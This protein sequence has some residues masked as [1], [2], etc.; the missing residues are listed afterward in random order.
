MQHKLSANE[1]IPGGK[2]YEHFLPEISEQ[3]HICAEIYFFVLKN[4]LQAKNIFS[5]KTD[6]E[7]PLSALNQLLKKERL[8]E[9]DKFPEV[10]FLQNRKNCFWIRIQT[11]ILFINGSTQE[12]VHRLHIPKESKKLDFNEKS[13]AFAYTL[14]NGLYLLLA[15]GT[16]IPVSTNRNRAITAGQAASRNEFG[17]TKGTFWSPQGSMLAFYQI[18]ERE[19]ADYPLVSIKEPI[20][21]LEKIKYPMAGK[22]SQQVK[23]GLYSVSQNKTIFLQAPDEKEAYLTCL[24]WSPDEKQIYLAELKRSQKV[25]QLKRFSA[26]DGLLEKVLFSESDEKY[27]EPQYPLLFLDEN[28]KRFLWQS[29]RDGFNHLY[30]YDEKGNLQQQLTH[31]DWEVCELSGYEKATQRIIFSSTAQSPLNRNFYAIH[32]DSGNM[33]LLTPEEGVHQIVISEE[34]GLFID[35]F[36]SVQTPGELFL[37]SLSDGK[38]LRTLHHAPNPYAG[39]LMPKTEIGVFRQKETLPEIYYRITYPP[40][41]KPGRKYP[42]LFYVY[43]GPH[44]Q[45]VRNEWNGG[46]KGFERFMANEGYVVFYMD[47]RGSAFRGKA[48]EEAIWLNIGK[49]QLDDYRFALH[50]LLST[51][52]CVDE[53]KVGV[54]GW[55]FGGFMAASLMLKAPDLFQAG[56]AGGAVID[57]AFY[58]TMYTERYMKTPVE[59]PN[60]Y[61]ENNLQNFIDNLQGELLFIHCDNDPIVLWQHTLSFLKKSVIS[62]KQV[63]YF[64]YPGHDH[65]V[66]GT[67]RVHLMQKVKRFFDEKLNV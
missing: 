23:V 54:Y 22:K 28:G 48:F 67:D 8:K 58:E 47:P 53:K 66:Q 21:T 3:I 55:S 1:L 37:R 9:T 59:N 39:Y 27:V 60:G 34:N 2:S 7:F 51:K 56:V 18:D 20:A 25:F 45:L 19:V 12:I 44:I 15:D 52:K 24:T 29:R 26:H 49:I 17:I 40:K 61:T 64:V 4:V 33:T 38:I 65:N 10:H 63:D 36:N 46:T 11:K 14:K 30:I 5:G 35:R 31:G 13:N 42:L 50:R 6:W 62:Q 57:W 43:G 16:N 41:M 32:P